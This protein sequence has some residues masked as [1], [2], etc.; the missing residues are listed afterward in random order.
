MFASF[1]PVASCCAPFLQSGNHGSINATCS[2]EVGFPQSSDGQPL[3][4]T[5]GNFL[6]PTDMLAMRTDGPKWNHP[7]LYGF[8]AASC[9]FLMEKGKSMKVEIESLPEWPSLRGNLRK[10]FDDY[11]SEIW[12][13]DDD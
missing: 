8:F 5:I 7:K 9:F 11:E 10:R 2:H 12:P 1:E 6:L 13:L 3:C 4:I